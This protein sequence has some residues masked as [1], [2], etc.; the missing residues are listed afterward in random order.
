MHATTAKTGRPPRRGRWLTRALLILLA[1]VLAVL[2]LG[3]LV[4]YL[5]LRASLPDL[6]GTR[7]VSGLDREAVLLRDDQGRVHIEAQTRQDV[8]F[9]LGF[10]HGQDRFFQMDLQRRDAAGELSSLF[11]RLALNRDRVTRVHRFRARAARN[12][13]V[14]SPDVQHLLEAYAE[15]VNAGLKDLG[16]VPF[17]YT[18]LRV[19]PE[20][21]RAEEA[22]LTLFAMTLVLQD[23]E[24]RRERARGVL[25]ETFPAPLY[26][27][28]HSSGGQ[29]E[30]PLSGALFD[31]PP[32]PAVSLGDLPEFH[33][34]MTYQ[35]FQT[36]ELLPGSN[37]WAVAGTLTE[38]GGALVADDMHLGHGVPNIWYRASWTDPRHGRIVTGV[39]LPGVPFMVAGSN[40]RVAWGFTNTQGDWSDVIHLEVSDDGARYRAPEGWRPF[41]R[42]DESIE[43]KG[44]APMSF[45]VLETHWGPVI[46]EDHAGRTLALRWTAHDPEGANFNFTEIEQVDTVHAVVARAHRFGIP[47]QNLVLGD[48][49]GNIAWTIAGPIPRRVGF[50]GQLPGVWHDTGRRWDGYYDHEEHPR[51]VNPPSGRIWTANARVASGAD[52][53]KIGND[54]QAL[55]ARQQQ[56][57]DRLFEQDR[58]D[59]ND[60][61]RIQLDN[62]AR[63]LARWRERLLALPPDGDVDAAPELADRLAEARSLVNDWSGHAAADDVGYRIVHDYRSAVLARIAAPFERAVQA[64]ETRFATWRA[65]RQFET[66]A[67]TLLESRPPQLLNPDFDSWQALEQDAFREVVAS[68]SAQGPLTEA[69]WGERNR[70]E[71]AHP[72]ANAIPL[73]GPWL[74]RLPDPPMS[75]DTQMPHVQGPRWGASQRFAISPGREESAFLHMPAGQSSHPLSPY[76]DA[77]HEDWVNGTP[78]PLRFQAAKHRLTLRPR[79]E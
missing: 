47:H 58:F 49:D 66:P 18:L 65:L 61:L 3:A 19:Q 57:R 17:E 6:D 24:G 14:A 15:G 27:F 29:W 38:H 63:F 56:I 60:M 78:T 68:L 8:A 35:P 54:G 4:G 28:L 69:R 41:E 75:G 44:E 20:P 40:G 52:H 33:A 22:F 30:A 34:P 21:W 73:L 7:T 11:G 48:A 10:A 79:A 76:F 70:L 12:F 23:E 43:I 46:G 9:A 55:G 67:W 62:E 64:R 74:L 2:V 31:E 37:N 53:A 72:L 77:G 36:S 5:F 51:S 26:D 50:D 32:V 59:E 25:A 1:G 16:Q 45:P 39:T 13:A 42:I 71:V